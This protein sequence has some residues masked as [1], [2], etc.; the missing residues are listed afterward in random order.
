[1][2]YYIDSSD[3]TDGEKVKNLPME[4][5][6]ASNLIDH[7]SG[8]SFDPV[9]KNAILNSAGNTPADIRMATKLI[10]EDRI[11]NKGRLGGEFKKEVVDGY[12]YERFDQGRNHLTGIPEVDNILRYYITCD[13]RVI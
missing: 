13:A 6:Y 12:S 9:V 4:I 8:K 2:S 3:I 5:E 7:F 11:A 1:M 10:V